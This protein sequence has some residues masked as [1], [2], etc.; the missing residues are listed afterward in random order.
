MSGLAINQGH[1]PCSTCPIHRWSI[2]SGLSVADLEQLPMAVDDLSAPEG[3]VLSREGLPAHRAFVVR[4]GVVKLEKAGPDGNHL[5]HLL[6]SGDIW[7]F[8]GLDQAYYAHTATTLEAAHICCLEI[9]ALQEW[10]ERDPRVRQAIRRRL[11]Q[12]HLDTED[13]L[14]LLLSTNAELRVIGFLLRWC[15]DYPDRYKVSLPLRRQ[16]LANYLGMSKE[17]LSRIMARL[18]RQGLLHEQQGWIQV[19]FTRLRAVSAGNSKSVDDPTG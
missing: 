10:C 14:L 9:K 13:H 19:D 7:G 12:A 18:K 4:Q 8:E 3:T 17:H 5:V 2:F 6:R 11:Q 15:R 16:E 1:A